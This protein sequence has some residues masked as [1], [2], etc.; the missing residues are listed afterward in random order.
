MRGDRCFFPQKNGLFQL[1]GFVLWELHPR[2][3][4]KN[5]KTGLWKHW[6]KYFTNVFGD[7]ILTRRENIYDCQILRKSQINHTDI[8]QGKQP[9]TPCIEKQRFCL[10]VILT[11]VWKSPFLKVIKETL[12]IPQAY[13]TY[14]IRNSCAFLD[15]KSSLCL[16]IPIFLKR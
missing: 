8:P 7:I 10:F 5:S 16:Y 6:S 2:R 14:P 12:T 11:L 3:R 1:L 9:R 15:P 13:I 4:N